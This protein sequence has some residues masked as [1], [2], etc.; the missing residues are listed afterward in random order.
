MASAG[1]NGRL[2]V[3]MGGLV[4]PMLGFKCCDSLVVSKMNFIF[5]SYLEYFGIIIPTD[6]HIFHFFLFHIFGII[7]PTDYSNIFQ[8][9]GEKP[10]TR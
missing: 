7:I 10:P 1:E 6:F 8:R 9:G 3:N 4:A 5:P 2:R